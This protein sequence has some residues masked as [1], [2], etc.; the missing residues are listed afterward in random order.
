MSAE[1]V[2]QP[3]P[4]QKQ[5]LI[6]KFRIAYKAAL[7]DAEVQVA[8]TKTEGWLS[9]Y[10]QNRKADLEARR[11]MAKCLHTHATQMEDFGVGED[12]EKS[13][14]DTVKQSAELRT[15]NAAFES[16]VVERICAP[17]KACERIIQ[18]YKHAATRAEHDAPLHN[19][20]LEQLMV[21]EIQK[22]PKAMFN[23]ET[24]QVEIVEP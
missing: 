11:T 18:E 9:L 10:S 7:A 14:K 3:A 4:N 16:Q 17:V 15:A 8:M 22:Q 13:I 1:P 23:A 24:G 20:G 6:Q 5:D 2:P 12:E 19:V 21:M